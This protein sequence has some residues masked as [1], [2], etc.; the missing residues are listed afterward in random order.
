M[1]VWNFVERRKFVRYEVK[2]PLRNL[3]LYA[4][5]SKFCATN[6]ISAKGIG[7]IS[8][9]EMAVGTR[10][11]LSLDTPDSSEHV[12]IS[13]T[14]V[15]SVQVGPNRYRAG[16]ALEDGSN[17]KAVPLVLRSIQTRYY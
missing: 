17:I 14:V 1:A 6:D 2:F 12:L 5:V 10:L 8:S 4:K 11:Q 7:C 3:D 15:W 13:G 9:D 16:I